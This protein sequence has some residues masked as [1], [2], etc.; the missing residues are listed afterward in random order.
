MA[1]EE[2]PSAAA[3]SW[4]NTL[5]PSEARV[6]LARC[7]GAAR[8]VEAMLQRRP[9]RS[10]AA[11]LQEADAAWGEL[12][13]ADF[14]EAFSHHPEIGV[15]LD[16]LRRK[17][18]ATADLSRGE[19]AGAAGASEAILGALRSQNQAYRA[20]FG[21]SF[22]VCATGKTASEM[23]ALLQDRLG[24]EPEAELAVAAAEQAKITRLRLEK[25]TP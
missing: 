20:R 1:S 7:C 3:L 11:L 18:A 5:P 14:L 22:I 2:R 21:Y 6:A 24:N 23:L 15:S 19:Q 9:F 13:A 4:L 8:W 16:E 10:P 17:F 25:L 12:T